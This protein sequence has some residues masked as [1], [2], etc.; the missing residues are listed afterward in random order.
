MGSDISG[1]IISDSG[2]LLESPNLKVYSFLDLKTATK[3]FKPDS[4]LGQGGFGKVYRGW[5]DATTLAPSRVGSGMI[6]A[7]KRLNSESVQ[8]FAEWRVR[9]I[10]LISNTI[11]VILISSLLENKQTNLAQLSRN[12]IKMKEELTIPIK[13]RL[14][15][16]N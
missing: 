15:Q 10:S 13:K 5:V 2:K 6:V 14:L 12:S 7:I 16:N 4:M 1:R 8:G 11:F 9:S 3:N